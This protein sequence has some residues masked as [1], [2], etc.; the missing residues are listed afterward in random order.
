MKVNG[1]L[2]MGVMEGRDYKEPQGNFW[3]DMCVHFLDCG[4]NFTSVNIKLS[5]YIY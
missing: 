2:G 5:N 4:Y 3:E 1:C